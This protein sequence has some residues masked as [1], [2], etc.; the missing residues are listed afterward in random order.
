[1]ANVPY[2]GGA[3]GITPPGGNQGAPGS[4]VANWTPDLVRGQ[5]TFTQALMVKF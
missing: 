1:M 5:S 3:G 2:F 4:V